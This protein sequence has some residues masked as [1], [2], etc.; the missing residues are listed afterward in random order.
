LLE[1]GEP[2]CAAF[3]L[4]QI[5]CQTPLFRSWKW[6][7]ISDCC[8]GDMASFKAFPRRLLFP[9]SGCP[10]AAVEWAGND[11][12]P[13]HALQSGNTRHPSF[14]S[15]LFTYRSLSPYKWRPSYPS[16][17]TF[18]C[19]FSSNSDPFFSCF[20]CRCHSF[21]RIFVSPTFPPPA[22]SLILDRLPR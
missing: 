3:S 15:L 11:A 1:A 5:L 17:Q 10:S 21:K 6:I 14:L 18:L 19:T 12:R 22:R 16:L 9:T 13:L 7:L 20:F 2:D 8:L 4:F